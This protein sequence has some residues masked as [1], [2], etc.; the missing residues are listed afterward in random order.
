MR[1]AVGSAVG[2]IGDRV[3]GIKNTVFGALSGA[4]EWLR[5]VG[6]DLIQGLIN[7]IGDMFGWVRDKI[8]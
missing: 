8:L 5:G 4:G 3:R 2:F 1:N 7:G 6:R